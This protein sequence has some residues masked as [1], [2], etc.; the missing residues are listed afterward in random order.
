MKK[1]KKIMAVVAAM[2]MTAAMSFTTMAASITINST[3][4]DAQTEKN[5]TEYTYY[6]ILKADTSTFTVGEDGKQ[7]AGEN[8]TYYVDNETLANALPTTIFNVTRVSGENRWNVE[9]KAEY[10]AQDVL[11]AVNVETVKNAVTTK[12]T[13][14]M[15]TDKKAVAD[16]LVPGYYLVLSSN[17]TNA[18][19]QTLAD[20]TIDEKNTYPTIDKNITGENGK[21]IK[22]T[23][24]DDVNIGDKVT[25]TVPVSI[26]ADVAEK[27]I[28][29]ADRMF[30]GLTLDT[31]LKDDQNLN[32]SFSAAA[33][34]G[35]YNIYTITIPADKVLALKG[36]TVTFTY[37]ATLNDQAV[38]NGDNKNFVKLQY[39]NYTTKEHEVTT[40]THKVEVDKR[41]GADKTAA[42]LAGVKFTLTRDNNGTT[43][44]YQAK[45]DDASVWTTTSTE[46]TTDDKNNIVFDG[47]D[48]G[49]YTLTETFTPAGY[50]PLSAPITVTVAEDGTVTYT[51]TD[52]HNT[53]NNQSA[54]SGVIKVINVTGSTL[55]STGGMGTTILYVAGAILVIAGAAVLVIKKRHEA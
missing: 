20:V 49:T 23:K 28:V 13:F 25:Y 30:K 53:A 6:Q 10:T 36:K 2:A 7:A 1:F 46:F 19:L 37:Q 35:D 31:I 55:P 40:Q 22:A 15:G 4:D 24:A 32:L 17:G 47:L 26:P 18:V 14:K 5:E 39:D 12:G 38:I 27:E 54:E 41:V 11:N 34:D 8:V 42:K 45:K 3:A 44:Y 50:N 48:A 9:A 52:L 33:V 16:N 29:I 21:D 43:E 51:S